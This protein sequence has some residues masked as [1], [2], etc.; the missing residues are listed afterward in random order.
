V[1][2]DEGHRAYGE[3]AR[4]TIRNFNPSFILELSATPPNNSNDLVKITGRELLEE[5]M[6][7]LDIHLTN[8]TSLDWQDTLLASVKLNII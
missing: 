1:I 6:I 5:E 2:I 3:L 4:N 8:K 7:K